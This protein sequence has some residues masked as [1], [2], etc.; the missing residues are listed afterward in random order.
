MSYEYRLVFND[1]PLMQCVIGF[2]RSSDAFIEAKGQEIYL[3]DPL[4]KSLAEYDARLILES[5]LSIWLELNFRATGLYDLMKKALKDG[6][7]RCY[8]DGDL[9][10]E[11]SLKEVFLVGG[12]R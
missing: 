9:S 3:K 6:V 4:L 10:D 2:L 5:D 7:V 12:E 8:E 11:V 1:S